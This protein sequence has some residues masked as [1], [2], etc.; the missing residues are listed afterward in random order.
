MAGVSWSNPVIPESIKLSLP[1][2]HGQGQSYEPYLHSEGR[3]VKPW[4]SVEPIVSCFSIGRGT[5]WWSEQ[6]YSVL[7]EEMT[8]QNRMKKTPLMWSSWG[9]RRKG[10][11]IFSW[12]G[13]RPWKYIPAIIL[14]WWWCWSRMLAATTPESEIHMLTLLMSTQSLNCLH[15]TS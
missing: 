9:K 13:T 10:S 12:G 11:S 14:H 6:S 7:V 15:P 8:S 5:F 3:L 1:H 2:L 4:P